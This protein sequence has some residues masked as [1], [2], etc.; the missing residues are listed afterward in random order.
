ME[1]VVIFCISFV[2]IF[3]AVCAVNIPHTQEAEGK[4]LFTF[5]VH[6]LIGLGILSR[7]HIYP[8]LLNFSNLKI[9]CSVSGLFSICFYEFA[10][11]LYFDTFPPT[12]HSQCE[13]NMQLLWSNYGENQRC[14]WG[15]RVEILFVTSSNC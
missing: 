13:N 3:S 11:G 9:N 8:L 12:P 6:I 15:L 10:Y 7:I 14:L 1:G 2:Q 5:K 4:V